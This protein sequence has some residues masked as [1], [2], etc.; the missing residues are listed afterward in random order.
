MYHF[1]GRHI[2]TAS[3]SGWFFFGTEFSTVV[4]FIQINK[5]LLY[6]LFDRFIKDSK[7]C[8]ICDHWID[9]V[10]HKF[11]NL[12]MLMLHATNDNKEGNKKHDTIHVHV[13]LLVLPMKEMIT[14]H[15]L[16]VYVNS[17]E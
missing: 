2:C 7:W 15:Y 17:P 5:I 4:S 11:N 3:I 6:T 10:P 8:F 1:K 14:H 9:M 16:R 13:Y 12:Y